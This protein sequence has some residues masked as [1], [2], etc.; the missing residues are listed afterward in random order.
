MKNPDAERK[1]LSATCFEVMEYELEVDSPNTL[2]E[3]ENLEVNLN[4]KKAPA[5]GNYTYGALLI[6]ED[7]YRAEINVSSNGTVDGTDIFVNG[8]DIINEFGINSTNYESKF[9]KDE[10]TTEIQT[11]IGEGNGTISIGEDNQNTLSLTTFDLPPGDY[12][13]FAAAY[14]NGKGLASIAQKELTICTAKKSNGSDKKQKE[15]KT[16]TC[17]QRVRVLP[18]WKPSSPFLRPQAH[19]DSTISNLR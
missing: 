5:Q 6:K 1:V 8:I 15:I 7:A 3:C 10:L 17:Q 9:S 18:P 2:K 12:L 14:E 16:P 13:L 19:S 11:M 4:L